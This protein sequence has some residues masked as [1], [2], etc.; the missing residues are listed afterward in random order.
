MNGVRK[1]P[2]AT[3]VCVLKIVLLIKSN[4]SYKGNGVKGQTLK[5]IAPL[6]LKFLKKI[7]ITLTCSINKKKIQER[8]L[9]K[10][11]FGFRLILNDGIYRPRTSSGV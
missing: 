10:N 4:S 8:S 5:D 1:S 9:V 7:A 6:R 11:V 2:N 3:S